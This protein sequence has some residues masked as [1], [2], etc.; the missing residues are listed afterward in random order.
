MNHRYGPRMRLNAPPWPLPI[1]Y[2]GSAVQRASQRASNLLRYCSVVDRLGG[3]S[4][5]T[6]VPCLA[7]RVPRLP[8]RSSRRTIPGGAGAQSYRNEGSVRNDQ[9]PAPSTL[10]MQ[11]TMS[12]LN[13]YR[14]VT[15]TDYCCIV[16]ACILHNI[17][18]ILKDTNENVYKRSYTRQPNGGLASVSTATYCFRTSLDQPATSTNYISPPPLR[19]ILWK[20]SLAIQSLV[21]N[22]FIYYTG[23]YSRGDKN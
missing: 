12:I 18:C 13:M 3:R 6:T 16:Y 17:L 4:Q 10:V 2:V 1:G 23:S 7:R 22:F 11:W 8:D 20:L 5:E 15:Y 9:A 14:L 19:S 21:K